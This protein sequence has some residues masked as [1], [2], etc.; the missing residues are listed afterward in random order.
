MERAGRTARPLLALARVRRRRAS[1]RNPRRNKG[2]VVRNKAES[3]PAELP[4]QKRPAPH[5]VFGLPEPVDPHKHMNDVCR[6][7]T[8]DGVVHVCTVTEAST[9]QSWNGRNQEQYVRY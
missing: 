3:K 6:V 2:D 4:I 9:I 1:N 7:L 8:P 5:L